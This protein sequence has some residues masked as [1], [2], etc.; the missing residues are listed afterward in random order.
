MSLK[1]DQL[2][3]G[4]SIDVHFNFRRL[5]YFLPARSCHCHISK[6]YYHSDSM[7][8]IG[9]NNKY[10]KYYNS[11]IFPMH[12]HFARSITLGIE[13]NLYQQKRLI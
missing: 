12:C 10:R 8:M 6:K 13:L 11:Y 2:E 1:S 4:F 3:L 7:Q 5:S 9:I